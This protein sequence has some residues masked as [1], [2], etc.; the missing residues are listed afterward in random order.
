MTTLILAAP[1][2]NSYVHIPQYAGFKGLKLNYCVYGMPFSL[3]AY[4]SMKENAQLGFLDFTRSNGSSLNLTFTNN[5][6][7]NHSAYVFA[8][9][10]NILSFRG[11]MLSYL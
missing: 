3:D 11:A 9:K 6:D 7:N 10:H 2:V 5:V 4:K 8:V 1:V